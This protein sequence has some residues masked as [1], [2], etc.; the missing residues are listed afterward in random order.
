MSVTERLEHLEAEVAEL[1][2]EI[3]AL[4]PRVS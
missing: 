4:K 2:K 1:R 3:E